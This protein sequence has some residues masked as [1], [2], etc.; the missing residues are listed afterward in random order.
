MPIIE[1]SDLYRVNIEELDQQH[2]QLLNIVNEFDEA[3]ETKK[4]EET[5][6]NIL[7]NLLDYADMHFKKE[8]ELMDQHGYPEIAEH[9]KQHDDLLEE[10]FHI[11]KNFIGSDRDAAFQTVFLLGDWLLNHTDIDDKKLAKYLHSK[12]VT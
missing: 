4:E 7:K 5:T 3:V 9:K 10:L 8:E 12:G 6:K 1:W 2:K 11:Y